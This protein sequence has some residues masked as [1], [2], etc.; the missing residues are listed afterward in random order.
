M[1][2]AWP[3]ATI[4]PSAWIAT[5]SALLTPADPGTMLMLFVPML[6]LYEFSILL[7]EVVGRRD[8]GSDGRAEAT[9]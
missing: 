3:T 1:E 5:A 8:R 2:A 7:V 4:L 9:E 6:L